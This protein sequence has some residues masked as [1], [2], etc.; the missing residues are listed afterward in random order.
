MSIPQ[1]QTSVRR[2]PVQVDEY[3]SDYEEGLREFPINRH[4]MARS[5]ME[6]KLSRSVR[7]HL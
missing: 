6:I 3:E 4:S 7:F 1:V 2:K 5:G